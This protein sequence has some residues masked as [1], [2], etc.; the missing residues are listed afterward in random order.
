MTLFHDLVYYRVGG[1]RISKN[2][3]V[4]GLASGTS[5]LARV[6]KKAQ[7]AAGQSVVRKKQT[8]S[9]PSQN[10]LNWVVPK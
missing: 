10:I 7:K 3:K 2:V 5:E 4:N 8:C 9:C 6:A 1:F